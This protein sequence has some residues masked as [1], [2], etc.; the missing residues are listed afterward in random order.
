VSVTKIDCGDYLITYKDW[1]GFEQKIQVKKDKFDSQV[2][3]KQA[4]Q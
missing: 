1:H 4:N 3:K 2:V